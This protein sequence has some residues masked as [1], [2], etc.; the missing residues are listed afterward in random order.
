MA[1]NQSNTCI[2]CLKSQIDITEGISKQ[3]VLH[4]CRECNRYMRPP[5]TKC[6]LESSE[7][8]TICL[9]QVK[10]LMRVKLID[11]GFEW[12][13]PHSKRIKVKLTVQKEVAKNTLLQQTFIVEYVI[14]NLQCDDCKKTYTPHTW[15]AQVQVR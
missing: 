10:G 6:E 14:E 11:A 2:D 9:K 12:T 7:L 5:W 15:V 1:P 13:E 3:L 8:L 4:H